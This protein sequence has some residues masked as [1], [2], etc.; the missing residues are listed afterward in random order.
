L[1]HFPIAEKAKGEQGKWRGKR[2]ASFRLLL[3]EAGEGD[4][5]LEHHM[6]V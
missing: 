2:C 5:H 1:L 6:G 4:H 3:A